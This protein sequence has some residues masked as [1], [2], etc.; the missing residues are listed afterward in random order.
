MKWQKMC[1]D[2]DLIDEPD[3]TTGKASGPLTSARVDLVFK[4]LCGNVQTMTFEQFMNGCVQVALCKYPHIPKAYEALSVLYTEHFSKFL[5]PHAELLSV[6]GSGGDSGD[7]S[8]FDAVKPVKEGILM[9][10]QGYFCQELNPYFGQQTAS[11]ESVSMKAFLS[12]MHDFEIAPHLVPKPIC[13]SVFREVLKAKIPESFFKK[14]FES[15]DPASYHACKGRLFTLGHFIISLYL[16]G[17]KLSPSLLLPSE[18]LH[19]AA[20]AQ[21][22][23]LPGGHNESNL[24]PADVIARLLERMDISQPGKNRFTAERAKSLP[25]HLQ[26][27]SLGVNGTLGLFA[28]CPEPR[29][30]DAAALKLSG[31]GAGA[32]SGVAG[33]RGGPAGANYLRPTSSAAAHV[34]GNVTRQLQLSPGSQHATPSASSTAPHFFSTTGGSSTVLAGTTGAAK[35]SSYGAKKSSLKTNVL[36]GAPAGANLNTA[37]LLPDDVSH[38]LDEHE[39]VEEEHLLSQLFLHYTSLG[40]PLNRSQMSSLKFNRFLRDAGLLPLECQGA[41][42]FDARSLQPKFGSSGADAVSFFCA[43]ILRPLSEGLLSSTSNKYGNAANLVAGSIDVSQFAVEMGK[44]SMVDLFHSPNVAEG[45]NKVFTYYADQNIGSGGVGSRFCQ[46]FEITEELAHL[47]LQRIFQDCAHVEQVEQKS[48][49]VEPAASGTT[50]NPGLSKLGF[51]LAL[52]LVAVKLSPSQMAGGGQSSSPAPLTEQ[53]VALLHKL[54]HSL[55]MKVRS[56]ILSRHRPA[57]GLLAEGSAVSKFACG[58]ADGLSCGHFAFLGCDGTGVARGR[59]ADIGKIL[60]HPAILKA[61]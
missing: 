15:D 25:L 10:Y 60:P 44:K 58:Y 50:A 41:V 54:N 31:A 61:K 34:G 57:V 36:S 43:K 42:S 18:D 16:V 11:L 29:D 7:F 8:F 9:L 1:L 5:N 13:L 12:C 21:L 59:P 4:K 27:A 46:D 30:A 49:G 53:V 40:D 14:F 23:V 3:P 32:V 28:F 39:L 38:F 6:F 26:K 37:A 22:D 19:G 52:V 47:P 33:T 45:I 17:K 24:P 48:S 55:G 2:A 20:A 51:Q 35:K 56:S